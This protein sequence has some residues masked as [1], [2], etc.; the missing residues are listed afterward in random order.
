M[1][2]GLPS[3][4]LFAVYEDMGEGVES[5]ENCTNTYAI[6][7]WMGH[8]RDISVIVFLF[9]TWPNVFECHFYRLLH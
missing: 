5:E 6:L 2:K 3:G 4:A 8:R 9:G 7:L 1:K